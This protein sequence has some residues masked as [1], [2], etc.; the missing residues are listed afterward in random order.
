MTAGARKAGFSQKM[1][2]DVKVGGTLTQISRNR[3]LAMYKHAIT[4]KNVGYQYRKEK[5]ILRRSRLVIKIFQSCESL[6]GQL[7]E[8]TEFSEF[9]EVALLKSKMPTANRVKD[10]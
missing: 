9:F 4:F 5:A 6:D 3:V 1:R 7:E 2:R 8:Q 10:I